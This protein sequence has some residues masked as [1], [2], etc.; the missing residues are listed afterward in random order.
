MQNVEFH[1]DMSLNFL[2][3]ETQSTTSAIYVTHYSC[4]HFH[5]S[6]FENG[7]KQDRLKKTLQSQN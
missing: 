2:F 5:K 1:E 4:G 7:F 6:L 3:S